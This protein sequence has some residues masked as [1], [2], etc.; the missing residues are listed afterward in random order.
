[1]KNKIEL[2]EQKKEQIRRQALANEYL[3]NMMKESSIASDI[4]EDIGL[5]FMDLPSNRTSGLLSIFSTKKS[6]GSS[7]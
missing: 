2:N 3:Y 1:M 4:D 7:F 5:D 6:A